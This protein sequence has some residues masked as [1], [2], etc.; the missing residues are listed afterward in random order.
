MKHPCI[1]VGIASAAVLLT[2]HLLDA[3]VRS[4]LVGVE[5]STIRIWIWCAGGLLMLVLWLTYGYCMV[6]DAREKKDQLPDFPCLADM[7]NY[8]RKEAREQIAR[9]EAL[10]AKLEA[11]KL[12]KQT[13]SGDGP[14]A[15]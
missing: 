9:L 15:A 1:A 12:N 5:Q 3:A 6:C 7:N 11:V 4:E 8:L 2:T 10:Q 13:R 14:K